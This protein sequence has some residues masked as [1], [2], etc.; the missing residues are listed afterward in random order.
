MRTRVQFNVPLHLPLPLPLPLSLSLFPRSLFALPA[1]SLNLLRPLLG[2]FGAFQRHE[3]EIRPAAGII[4]AVQV[5]VEPGRLAGMAWRVHQ[6]GWRGR[7]VG[8]RNWAIAFCF[9][10][11]GWLLFY[12]HGSWCWRGWSRRWSWR[13]SSDRSGRGRVFKALGGSWRRSGDWKRP[14]FIWGWGWGWRCTFIGWSRMRGS[15]FVALVWVVTIPL[16][17]RRVMAGRSR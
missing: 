14:R 16:S 5:F 1:R 8:R 4:S 17:I 7:A 10:F 9:T 15:P 13:R 12:L 2:K 6:F 3:V 11:L